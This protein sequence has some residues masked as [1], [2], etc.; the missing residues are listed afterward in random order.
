MPE[1][2]PA[3]PSPMNLDATLSQ[4]DEFLRYLGGGVSFCEDRGYGWNLISEGW[5]REFIADHFR[6]LPE[7]KS[8]L[9]E[10]WARLQARETIADH[11]PSTKQFDEVFARRKSQR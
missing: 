2:E 5:R 3:Q 11:L 6:R 4:I 1:S 7:L 8:L 10:M 9:P